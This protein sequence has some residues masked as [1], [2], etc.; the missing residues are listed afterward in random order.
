[1]KNINRA[2][3]FFQAYSTTPW[4]RQVQVIGLFSAFVIVVALVAS[5]YLWVTS[6]ASTYG[7]QVQ[8]IQATAQ[9]VEENIEDLTVRL[10][11]LTTTERMKELAEE[12]GYRHLTT[13]S[14]EYLVVPGYPEDQPLVIAPQ[15]L[16]S[17]VASSRELPPEY[18]QSLIDWIRQVI[19][20][21][22]LG[23]GASEAG[24]GEN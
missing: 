16:A 24:G 7:R 11:E 20:K 15:S 13:G 4:R 18:T 3:R 17:P 9:V 22:S 8:E 23:T 2:Q 1:M 21:I 19:F 14:L 6:L 5:A 10:S 12:N